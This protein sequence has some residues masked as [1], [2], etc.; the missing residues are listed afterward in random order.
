MNL[1]IMLPLL[2][3]GMMVYA[4]LHVLRASST[5]EPMSPFLPKGKGICRNVVIAH[6]GI[7]EDQTENVAIANLLAGMV[8]GSG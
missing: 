1:K 5:T 7:V 4:M 2:A 3:L 6:P 8:H